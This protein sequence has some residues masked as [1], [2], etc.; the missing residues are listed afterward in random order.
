MREIP[1]SETNTE[2][3]VGIEL[4]ALGDPLDWEGL[5]GNGNPV[6]IEIGT[7]RGRFLILAGRA[8]PETNFLGLD[9]SRK[10]LA[11][12]RQRIGRRGLTN[13]RLVRTEALR[14]LPRIPDASVRRY[15]VY[16][17]DPWPK[18]RHHKRR[19]FQSPFL[20]QAWRTLVPGGRILLLTD[21]AEYFRAIG[22]TL[23]A[24]PLF[25]REESGFP[26]EALLDEDGLTNFEMKYRLEG[27]PIHRLA[28]LRLEPS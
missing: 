19:L 25:A 13:V 15:H 17:P 26:P 16:F 9:Y 18:K 4:D 14:L 7:G 10:F 11:M 21:H 20:E 3:L 2:E 27:R 5:F 23:E 6:E 12:A 8:R 22:E 1:V 28:C 24:T